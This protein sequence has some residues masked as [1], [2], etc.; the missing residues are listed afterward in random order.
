MTLSELWDAT[1]PRPSWQRA[2]DSLPVAPLEQIAAVVAY[3][4]VLMVAL[5]LLVTVRP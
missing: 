5:V 3:A 4:Y 1:E 2:L